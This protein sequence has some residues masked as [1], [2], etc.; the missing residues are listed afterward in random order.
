M[1]KI[2]YII[3]K[4][5]GKCNLNCNYCYYYNNFKVKEWNKKFSEE[6]LDITFN[7]ISSYTNDI[8]ICWHG[9]EPMLNGISYYK[10]VIELQK[11]YNL[12]IEHNIQTNGTLIND[13]WAEFFKKNNFS[14]GLSLDGDKKANDNSRLSNGISSYF[15][16]LRG[17]KILQKHQ[18][19]YGVLCYA[20]SNEDGKRIFKHFVNLGVKKIDFL[21]PIVSHKHVDE[22]NEDL[23]FKFFESVYTEWIE[24]N[25]PQVRIRLFDD[26]FSL[27]LD[28]Q[29]KNCI[30]KNSCFN[31]IT[32]EPNGDIG[33][34]ENHRVN[35]LNNYLLNLNIKNADFE[36][37]ENKLK[38]LSSI[39]ILIPDECSDCKF[40][41]FCN[42]G[43]AVERYRD[44]NNSYNMYCKIYKK[45]F[46][47]LAKSIIVKPKINDYV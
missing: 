27:L 13:E 28:Y 9:G 30:F 23:L 14:V 43:C 19:K 11:I 4:A 12:K 37:I 6:L 32:I 44:K 7:K 42:G 25:D 5:N 24:L 40:L 26:I 10:N 29:A 18:V 45:L 33:T 31:F 20:N 39:N 2:N 16:T 41:K 36:L 46:V 38:I 8:T 1:K 47:L 17:L 34:C 21:L 35:G 3:L 15:N 22:I